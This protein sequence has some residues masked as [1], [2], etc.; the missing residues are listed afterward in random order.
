[1]ARHRARKNLRSK[2]PADVVTSAQ[3]PATTVSELIATVIDS[4]SILHVVAD[5]INS[6]LSK[7]GNRVFGESSTEN[8]QFLGRTL[9][10][11]AGSRG[12]ARD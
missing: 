4:N 12:R 5:I 1:M 9:G 2:S 8:Y 3:K 10:A 6:A 11:I 7:P